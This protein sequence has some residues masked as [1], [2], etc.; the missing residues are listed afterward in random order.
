[1]RP[2]MTVGWAEH[3][4]AQQ[5]RLLTHSLIDPASGTST[6]VCVTPVLLRF[7]TLSTNLLNTAA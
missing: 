2:I 7:A 1:M 3:G 6:R 5:R 4:E